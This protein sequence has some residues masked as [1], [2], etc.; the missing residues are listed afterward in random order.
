VGA[1][2]ILRLQRTAG[3]AAVSQ[4]LTGR[5]TVQ[6]HA[7]ME[8]AAAAHIPTAAEQADMPTVA[9]APDLK[10][11]QAELEAE[12]KE[13]KKKIDAWKP[14]QTDDEK[15]KKAA[16]D[17]LE[18]DKKRMTEIDARIPEIARKLKVRVKGDEEETLTR[19]GIK[20][21]PAAWFADVSTVTFLDK[22]ATVH[23]SLAERLKKVETEV[24]KLPTPANGWVQEGHSTLRGPG[25]SLHSFGVAIDLNPGT[26]P[27]L[28]RPTGMYEPVGWT[29]AYLGAIERAL[30]LTKGKKLSDDPFFKR[31]DEADKDK[32]AEKSYDKLKEAS[33][34][35]AEYF[36]LVDSKNKP[37]F[38]DL[39]AKIAANDPT[40]KF[41]VW[42]KKIQADKTTV[43]TIGGNK[44]W[45]NPQKGFLNLNKELVKAM[46]SSAGGGLTWLGDDTI[47]GRD[48]MHFDTRGVGPIKGIWNSANK[49]FTGLGNG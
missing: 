23:K 1:A 24:K 26:N 10:R 5:P 39:K 25:E 14:P 27:W 8:P 48:I 21:G 45:T 7:G 41:D 12:K 6:R 4:L 20:G 32:R 30:L 15:Q 34:A 29:N 35:L 17:Q 36:A 43:T 3:N 31:P 37:D 19:N 18:A 47:A 42:K 9:Q 22:P 28:V 40:G 49:T 13:L 11:E 2:G 33:D 38:D 16:A 46:T 44:K